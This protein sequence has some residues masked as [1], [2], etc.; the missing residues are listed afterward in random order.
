MIKIFKKSK[1]AILPTYGTDMA[2]GFDLSACLSFNASIKGYSTT[3]EDFETF[4]SMDSQSRPYIDLIHNWRY[5]IPT[6]L[7]IDIPEFHHIE[8]FSRSGMSL[9]KGLTL[10]NGVGVIDED[11]TQELMLPI[12]NHS[13]EKIRIYHGDRIAQG[14]LKPNIK[15]SSCVIAEISERPEKV[16]N[17]SGGFG[18]TGVSNEQ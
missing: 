5:L 15:Y 9:K 13:Q 14:I 1:D 12:I 6:G 16:S 18:S 17:R 11:Y 3:N 10:I 4:V 8:I 2:A 7:I